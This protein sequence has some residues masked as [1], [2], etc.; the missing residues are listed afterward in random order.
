M[1]PHPSGLQN[2]P[3]GQDAPGPPDTPAELGQKPA[4]SSESNP[5]S[6]AETATEPVSIPNQQSN[7]IADAPPPPPRATK[8][9]M[10]AEVSPAG[11]KPSAW[12]QGKPGNQNGI[13]GRIVPVVPLIPATNRQAPRIGNADRGVNGKPDAAMNQGQ[14]ANDAAIQRQDAADAAKAA[15]QAAM[16]KLPA[17]PGQKPRAAQTNEGVDNLT[18]KVNEMR[19]NESI[20]HGRAGGPS[21]FTST[22]GRGGRRGAR[23]MGRGPE[24]PKADFD[25]ESANAKFNKD[26]LAKEVIASGSPTATPNEDYAASESNETNGTSDVV[27]PAAAV[28]YDKTSFFDNLSSEA[29]ER[30]DNDG[31]VRRGA[32]FR[33]EERKRNV[34]TFGQGSI[35]GNFRGRGRGRGQ[36][37]RRLWSRRPSRTAWR[38]QRCSGANYCS[39]DLDDGDGD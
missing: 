18:K 2:I 16:A 14:A 10:T 25:F 33:Y 15:V 9:D 27:I 24:V 7:V 22:R 11:P 36:R 19:T 30:A 5:A 29:K 8:P 31:T 3:G 4:P 1:H 6:R 21:G 38:R 17:G 12:Q 26:D 37:S 34:E 39:I 20:R 32:E 28:S 13:K 23:E 35:D